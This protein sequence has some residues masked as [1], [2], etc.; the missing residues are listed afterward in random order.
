MMMMMNF[1]P[2]V[3]TAQVVSGYCMIFRVT[4]FDSCH[5]G[6]PKTNLTKTR[7]RDSWWKWCK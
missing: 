4:A 1:H 7:S 6:H 3:M 2:E 5:S